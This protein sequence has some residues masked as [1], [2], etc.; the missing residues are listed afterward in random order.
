MLELWL[1]TLSICWLI[2]IIITVL[3]YIKLKKVDINWTIILGISV[4]LPV[5]NII[6]LIGLFFTDFKIRMK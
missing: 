2:F 4:L 5:V 1:V 6:V 3:D